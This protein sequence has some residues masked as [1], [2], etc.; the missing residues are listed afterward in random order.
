[1]RRCTIKLDQQIFGPPLNLLN[2][3]LGDSLGKQFRAMGIDNFGPAK[4]AQCH[5]IPPNKL[6]LKRTTNGFNFW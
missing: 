2:L 6:L 5:K 1:M 3:A 4:A